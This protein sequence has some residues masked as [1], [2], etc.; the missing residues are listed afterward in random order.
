MTGQLLQLDGGLGLTG[1][2]LLDADDARGGPE[3]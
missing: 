2:T 3:R 1:A